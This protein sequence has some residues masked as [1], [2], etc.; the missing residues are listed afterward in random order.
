MVAES[1]YGMV[2]IHQVREQEGVSITSS[3]VATR[4]PPCNPCA[5]FLAA[6]AEASATAA[7]AQ[8]VAI[9]AAPVSKAVKSP[10][11]ASIAKDSEKA[12]TPQPA[13]W[14]GTSG[15]PSSQVKL[16]HTHTLL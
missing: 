8:E 13:A 15:G 1:C 11:P 12:P 10:A 3:S 5:Q 14:N 4:D 6:D 16:E 2:I 7:A 9:G